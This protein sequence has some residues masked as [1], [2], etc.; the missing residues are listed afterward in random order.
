MKISGF[1]IFLTIALS[2]YGAGNIYVFIRGYNA[3]PEIPLIRRAYS[4]MF[5]FLALSFILGEFIEKSGII[6]GNRILVLIGSYWLAFLLYCILFTACIDLVRA[7]NFL[8]HFLPAADRMRAASVPQKLMTLVAALSLIIVAAGSYIAAHPR[9][10]TIDLY[11]DKPKTGAPRIDIIMISDLHLGSIIG[12]SRLEALVHTINKYGPDIV[13]IP[14][15]FFD[16]NLKPVI[17]DNMGGIIESIKSRCGIYA[18]TGNHEYIGG[19]EN[20]VAYMRKHKIHVLRDEAVRIDG[21]TVIG[22]EDRSINRFTGKKRRDLG[23]LLKGID[24]NLP[25]IVMDHQ[26]FN[27]RES[28]DCGID[29]HLSGH[30]HNGQ[31]WPVNFITDMIYD[32][33]YGYVVSGKTHIYVSSG[34]GTWGPPVRTSGWPELI[35][36]RLRFRE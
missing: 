6:F 14:G 30:T 7:S 8:F 25:V 32:V 5:L 27:I 23:E 24:M 17:E 19:A 26:P 2:I 4:L 13:L 33:A 22:R 12:R 16:E 3:L 31:L 1:I 21:L 11:I 34:Y 9:I 35:V 15:D 29:L 10:K 20:A 28:A 36:F 18:V